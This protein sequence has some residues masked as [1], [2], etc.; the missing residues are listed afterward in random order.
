V[1]NKRVRLHLLRAVVGAECICMCSCD[2]RNAG[3][4]MAY[5]RK[6]IQCIENENMRLFEINGKYPTTL[7]EFLSAVTTMDVRDDYACN[8][9]VIEL[10]RSRKDGWG[11][12]LVFE[13]KREGDGTMKVTVISY[14]PNGRRD[15]ETKGDDES[16]GHGDD[17]EGIIYLDPRTNKGGNA[18]GENSGSGRKDASGESNAG[19]K[20]GAKV[21]EG[22]KGRAGV[23]NS[24]R[25]RIDL[26]SR[27]DAD[28][29]AANPAT[30]RAS[31]G[32]FGGVSAG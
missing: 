12:P 21:S 8:D 4:M 14:G 19:K 17:L 27:S 23:R 30:Q 11:R 9:T 5:T 3:Y 20:G 15:I 32:F 2:G 24:V 13:S 29:R 7:D 10:I 26:R 6:E 22:R 25:K 16:R 31:G 18:A 28:D 1:C